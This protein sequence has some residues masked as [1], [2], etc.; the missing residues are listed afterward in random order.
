MDI[1]TLTKDARHIDRMCY[2]KPDI[3][4]FSTH[5][6]S[7]ALQYSGL[8]PELKNHARVSAHLK[9]KVDVWISSI[10]SPWTIV[11]PAPSMLE[12]LCN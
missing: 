4:F 7:P 10:I 6:T 3:F 2:H 1:P 9:V 12:E 5:Y 11:N 8:K